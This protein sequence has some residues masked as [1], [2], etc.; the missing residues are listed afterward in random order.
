MK[1]QK[2]GRTSRL[3]NGQ[4]RGLNA[5][6]FVQY[7]SG[8]ARFVNQIMIGGGGFS[9]AGDS[10]SLVVTQDNHNPVGLL[11]AGGSGATFANPIDAVL[12]AIGNMTIDG[13]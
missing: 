3:T 12:G 5:T 7:D 6:I 1:V 2:Y 13:Q 11:F 9:R 10:G 4:V 8:V